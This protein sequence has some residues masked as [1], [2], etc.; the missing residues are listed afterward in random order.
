[1]MEQFAVP[2]IIDQDEYI[3]KGTEGNK[4]RRDRKFSYSS[5]SGQGRGVGHDTEGQKVIC[6]NCKREILSLEDY[7]TWDDKE[8]CSDC[9]TKIRGVVK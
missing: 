2:R 8:C 5:N 1:M 6:Y 9:I 4:V 3:G 7:Y